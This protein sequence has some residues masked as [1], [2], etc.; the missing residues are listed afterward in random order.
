MEYWGPNLPSDDRYISLYGLYQFENGRCGEWSGLL[1]DMLKLQGI[2]SANKLVAYYQEAQLPNYTGYLNDVTEITAKNAATTFFGDL[3]TN[4]SITFLTD[5]NNGKISSYLFVKEHNFNLSPHAFFVNAPLDPNNIQTTQIGDKLLL[6][7]DLT[8]VAA[9]GNSNPKSTF[10]NHAILMYKQKNGN[11]GYYD[12]S[13]GKPASG[14]YGSLNDFEAD[15]VAGFG[16]VLNYDSPAGRVQI[17]WL[18]EK[19]TTSQQLT[20]K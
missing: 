5:G 17:L 2:K 1:L 3:Y 20:F 19:N 10:T 16:A 14:F 6:P 8:G 18:H 4:G 11:T 13:Y 7:S 9:Q 15:A 12:P